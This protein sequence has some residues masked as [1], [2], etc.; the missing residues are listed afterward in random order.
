MSLRRPLLS[1]SLLSLLALPAAAAAQSTSEVASSS[2]DLGH[3]PDQ[4]VLAEVLPALVDTELGSL[5]LGPAPAP[6]GSR[7]VRRSE[8][9]AALRRAG[10]SPAG[11]AIPR[12][13]IVRRGRVV[14]EREALEE[15]LRSPL[16]RELGSCRLESMSV[17]GRVTLARRP[18]EVSVAVRLPSSSQRGASSVGG[19]ATLSDGHTSVRLPFRARVT[20][21]PPVVAPGTRLWVEVRVGAV[22][23]RAQAEAR[24]PGRLGEIIRVRNLA[25]NAV[26]MARVLDT[27]TAEVV[28]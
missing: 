14:L 2:E 21:P 27:E 4:V 8:V 5:P 1:L 23:A 20:C 15:L 9:I 24:Q 16:S 6:G 13:T 18:S 11:L 7:Q 10:R 26:L 3:D 22:I 19:M 28:R 12:S 17:S 25:T